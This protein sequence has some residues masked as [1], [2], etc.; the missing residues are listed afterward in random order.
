MIIGAADQDLGVI[1]TA[2]K[3]IKNLLNGNLS[4]IRGSKINEF[5]PDKIAECHD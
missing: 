4:E 5:L 2:S 1:K 3:N